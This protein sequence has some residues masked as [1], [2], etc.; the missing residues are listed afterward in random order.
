[1]T[2]TY[3]RT[4]ACLSAACIMG[5]IV[6]S[7]SL[8]SDVVSILKAMYSGNR[9]QSNCIPC[10]KYIRGQQPMWEELLLFLSRYVPPIY[11]M[12]QGLCGEKS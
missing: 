11:C 3:L 10:S 9:C 12:M 6:L 2:K 1:M 8:W 7:I 4:L 5:K